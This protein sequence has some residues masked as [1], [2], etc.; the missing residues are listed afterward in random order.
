M[1]KESIFQAATIYLV[2]V[3]ITA[4]F[5]NQMAIL[6]S[7]AGAVDRDVIFGNALRWG[8]P[9]AALV[10][11]GGVLSD[12]L[13]RRKPTKPLCAEARP[14]RPEITVP[15][16]ASPE[17]QI[18]AGAIVPGVALFPEMDRIYA[19]A[20]GFKLC[21]AFSVLLASFLMLVA[22]TVLLAV[23]FTRHD[24]H[25]WWWKYVKLIFLAINCILG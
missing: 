4:L 11:L 12:R 23:G 10:A 15:W 24:D 16:Y 17:A 19:S 7:P 9:S 2:P 21:G 8:I 18:L 13:R 5:A 14:V 6:S 22:L 1:Q 20:L 3:L 25:L